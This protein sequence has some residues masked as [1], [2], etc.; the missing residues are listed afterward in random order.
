[1]ID[2][3]VACKWKAFSVISIASDP[4]IQ[5]SP[6]GDVIIDNDNITIITSNVSD[7]LTSGFLMAFSL[8][9]QKQQYERPKE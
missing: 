3:N 8:I 9:A 6:V 5:F 2:G 7:C 1:V 4:T